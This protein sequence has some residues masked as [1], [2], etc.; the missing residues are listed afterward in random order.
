MKKT[1]QFIK[2]TFGCHEWRWESDDFSGTYSGHVTKIG[3]RVCRVCRKGELD[4]IF[5]HD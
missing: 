1:W 3:W 5:K 2:C 4:F